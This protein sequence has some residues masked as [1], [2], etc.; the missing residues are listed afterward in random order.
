MFFVT[1]VVFTDVLYT[2]DIVFVDRMC[3][4]LWRPRSW[5][6]VLKSCHSF[7]SHHSSSNSEW[8]SRPNFLSIVRMQCNLSR[9]KKQKWFFSSVDICGV[10]LLLL[11]YVSA[12]DCATLT[13][14]CKWFMVRTFSANLNLNTLFVYFHFIGSFL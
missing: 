14:I 11:D 5:T 2:Q 4:I 7:C 3:L 12:S 9:I 13:L 10:S 1:T 8:K 6:T